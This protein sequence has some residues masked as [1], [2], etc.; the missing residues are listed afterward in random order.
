MLLL[1]TFVS[2]DKDNDPEPEPTETIAPYLFVLNSGTAGQNDA[3]L[4][5][6]NYETGELTADVFAE[7]LG[8]GLG[9][10]GNDIIVY[11]S[12][13]YIAVTNSKTIEVLDLGGKEIKQIQPD[14]SP[15]GFAVHGGNVYVTLYEGSVAKLDTASLAVAAKVSVGTNPEQL[16]VANNKLY[17]A[18][19]GGMNYPAPQ[20]STVSVIDLTSFAETKKIVVGLNPSAML[21]DSQGDVYVGCLGNWYDVPNVVKRIDT[22]T[23]DFSEVEGLCADNMAIYND[24][25]YS[26]Y[27][28]F[29]YVSYETVVYSYIYNAATETMIADKIMDQLPTDTY[30]V[31]VIDDKGNM[32]I[33]TSPTGSTGEAYIYDKDLKFV[34]KYAV[35]VF[36]VKAVSTK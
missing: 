35:G 13:M 36:P 4:T 11:G 2:C 5:A 7:K 9:D 26:I 15:R 34:D 28:S 24:K 8:R 1:F 31:S 27:A 30:T 17:V 29:D 25:I 32:C 6:Y 12:K 10:T 14:G 22:K 23:D 33:T 21:V 19:S 20:D 18:N 3:S 16:V